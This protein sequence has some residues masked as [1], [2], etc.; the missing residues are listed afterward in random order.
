MMEL[1]K[2]VLLVSL[3]IR[4]IHGAK[5]DKQVTREVDQSYETH[6]MGRFVKDLFHKSFLAKLTVIEG[7]A[8]AAL[9]A[10]TVP[11]G[12]DESRAVPMENFETLNNELL[13]LSGE[14]DSA[15]RE[16]LNG[17]DDA[18]NE[19]KNRLKGRYNASE[20]PSKASLEGRFR[21]A[22]RFSPMPEV[23]DFRVKL[24]ED[25]LAALKEQLREH[26]K[27][28]LKET[29]APSWAKLLKAVD[30]MS[31]SL[32]DPKK[33]FRDSL[34]ENLKDLCDTLP[35]L[36]LA[37]DKKFDQALGVVKKRLVVSP[38]M[39]RSDEARR[40]QVANEA[41]KISDAMKKFMGA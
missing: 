28:A 33:V 13:A 36:N 2:R 6:E 37:G 40:T 14:W 3:T 1:S 23:G 30:H 41:R 35:I 26:E 22:V 17:W 29:L 7:R 15:V 10:K 21:F 27:H 20:Y 25:H 9:Y 11:W 34:V 19:A 8:R 16:V 31:N 4:K 24:D 18:V 39:L 5:R 38:E 32:A 12:D